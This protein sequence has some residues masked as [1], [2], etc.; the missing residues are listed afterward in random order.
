MIEFKHERFRDEGKFF[1]SINNS[2]KMIGFVQVWSQSLEGVLIEVVYDEKVSNHLKISLYKYMERI[3][4]RK[5]VIF[6]SVS[7]DWSDCELLIKH[8]GSSEDKSGYLSKDL[9]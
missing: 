1:F 2:Q 9:T 4:R 8:L 6:L 5:G 7:K 3:L